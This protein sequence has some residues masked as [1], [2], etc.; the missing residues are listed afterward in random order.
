MGQEAL[1]PDRPQPGPALPAA[2]VSAV[3]AALRW[4]LE[5]AGVA[6]TPDIEQAAKLIANSN[7]SQVTRACYGYRLGAVAR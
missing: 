4:N 7:L 3:P 2:A 5:A 6:L 1:Q